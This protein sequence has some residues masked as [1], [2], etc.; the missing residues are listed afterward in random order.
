VSWIQHLVQHAGI[1]LGAGA[2]LA[3]QYYR[4]R[5]ESARALAVIGTVALVFGQL[6]WSVSFGIQRWLSPAPNAAQAIR[7]DYDA[8][9]SSAPQPAHTTPAPRH[10]LGFAM[11]YL[12]RRG[13]A[14]NAPVTIFLPVRI[15]GLRPE[16]RLLIDRSDVSLL[17]ESGLALFRGLNPGTL[18][19]PGPLP[20]PASAR[21]DAPQ[22]LQ[23]IELPA[24]AYR[25][26]GQ[27]KLRLR[28][29][30][31]LTLMKVAGRHVIPAANGVLR[32]QDLGACETRPDQ[33][34]SLI[35]LRCQKIGRTPFC[36]SFTVRTDAD[37]ENPE[38]FQCDP[39]YRPY[40]PSLTD[41]LNRFGVDIPIRDPSGLIHYPLEAAQTTALHILIKVYAVQEH[42]V[43]SLLTQTTRLADLSTGSGT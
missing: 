34:N 32:S 37:Q 2:I 28:L 42:A 31:S 23:V 43:R 11:N 30:Y 22:P 14:R 40:L 7:V 5:T 9:S 8:R 16:E 4:R 35:K 29:D 6:P 33:A 21:G 3:V 17:A 19:P 12:Q 39:D 26:L 27:Q 36:L 25:D 15:D 41:P 13:S 20:A 24:R 38:I 18:Y 10:E 1:L